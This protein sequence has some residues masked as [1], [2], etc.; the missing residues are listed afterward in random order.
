MRRTMTAVLLAAT[1][2]D[3]GACAP[4]EPVDPPG[5]PVSVAAKDPCAGKIGSRVRLG[6]PYRPGSPASFSTRGG[7]IFLTAH[8]FEHGAMDPAVGITTFYIGPAATPP[9]WDEP[10][11]VVTPLTASL[12]V[13]EGEYGRLNLIEGRYWLWTTTGGDVEVVSCASGGGVAAAPRLTLRQ[14]PPTR[15]DVQ[16]AAPGAAPAPGSILSDPAIDPV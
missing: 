15:G 16:P 5:A 7:P 3:A 2:A 14:Q 6:N 9:A 13:S 8:F 10:K 12:T 1:L 11:G 4:D